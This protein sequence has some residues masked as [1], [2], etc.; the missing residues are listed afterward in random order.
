MANSKVVEWS[1]LGARLE[2]LCPDKFDEIVEALRHTVEV[3]ELL[4]GRG[5]AIDGE[6]VVALIDAGKA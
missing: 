3:H 4:A 1:R 2:T 5:W 6:V